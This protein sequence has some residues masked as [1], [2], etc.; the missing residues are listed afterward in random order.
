MSSNAIFKGDDTGAFGN[1]FITIKVKNPLLYPILKL[2]AVT[3]SGSCIS[4]KKFTDENNF[5][6]ELIELTINYTADET[7]KLNQG[8]NVLNLVAYDMQN[9]QYTCK[10]S[11]T[12]YAKNGVISKN[13]RVC[14]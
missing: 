10:Q 11:L 4:N 14:C 8:S 12:F 5:Q 1:Q 6:Q 3:N 13:G 7:V 2:E 9:K